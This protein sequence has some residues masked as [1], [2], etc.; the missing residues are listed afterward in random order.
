MSNGGVRYTLVDT[1]ATNVPVVAA[2]THNA[3]FNI[4]GGAVDEVIV[5]FAFTLNAAGNIAADTSNIIDSFRLIL[6]GET[7]WDYQAQISDNAN[8]AAGTFGYLLNSLG[9]GRSVDVNTGGTGREYYVR[10]PV[11][12]NIAPG[13]SRLEYSLGYAALTGAGGA[14]TAASTEFWIRYNPAMQTTT[15]LGAA[16]TATYTA[17]T[18]QVVARVPQ[19]VPG[20]LAGILLQT[21]QDAADE[22]TDV[23]IVSQSDF[24]MDIDMWRM[25][26]GDLYNGVQFMDPA[27]ANGLQMGQ[28]LLGQIFIPL[29]QLSLADDLRMQVTANAG[30]T[31]SITPILTN[32]ISG[33]PAPAQ[34]QTETVPTNVAK[35]VLAASGAQL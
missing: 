11:G 10:I 13:I 19:N 24:A 16:T 32:S 1:S 15:T 18:Q 4:P 14:P 5:R 22:I 30:G 33:K 31:L 23:R 8:N 21:D 29:Y 20:T 3:G 26:N 12:R 35:S 28:A 17:T 34:V 25:L 2:A 6:N 9:P 7:V 27:T